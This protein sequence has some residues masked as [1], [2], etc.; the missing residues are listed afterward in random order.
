MIL[1]ITQT[2][3]FFNLLFAN[4]RDWWILFW[5]VM[6]IQLMI[7]E[8]LDFQ[9]NLH[10]DLDLLGQKQIRCWTHCKCPTNLI[11]ER[12][13]CS[14]CNQI[15]HPNKLQQMSKSISPTCVSLPICPTFY[16]W[17]HILNWIYL[18]QWL[19]KQ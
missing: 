6:V 8:Y 19:K 13:Y 9:Q 11:A 5:Q 10:Q 7:Q 4:K 3:V 17:D 1:Q 15:R 2:S 12:S 18:V 16:L 14:H